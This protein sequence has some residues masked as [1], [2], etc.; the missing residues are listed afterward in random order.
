MSSERKDYADLYKAFI[1]ELFVKRSKIVLGGT[2]ALNADGEPFV[3]YL[4]ANGSARNV[5][6]PV[7]ATNSG[8]VMLIVNVSAGANTITLQDDG[9]NAF[10]PAITVA[11]NKAVLVFC[12]G[13]TWRALVGA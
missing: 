1:R 7:A 6:L 3:Q 11:Q 5:K 9:G 8:K 13:T 2:Y 10:S 4:D 12:D